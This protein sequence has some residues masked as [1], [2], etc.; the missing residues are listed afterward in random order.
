MSKMK[1]KN[2]HIGRK[3]LFGFEI[4]VLILLVGVLF[5]YT[6]I[7][8]KMDQL[9]FNKNDTQ[10]QGGEPVQVEINESVSGSEVLSGYTNVALFGI[11][12]N[13]SDTIIIASI[14]NGTKEIKMVSLYRD[15]YL[16]VAED[17]YG[18]GIYDKCN[19]AYLRGGPVSAV[20]MLNTNL[21]LDIQNYVTVDF[22]ALSKAVDCLGGLDVDLSYEEIEHTNNYCIGTSEQVEGAEYTPIEKPPVP[23]D[24]SKIIGNY[25]LNGIQVTSYCRI[26][27]TA[28]MDMGR[29][30][31][32]RYILNLMADK[33]KKSSLTTLNKILDEVFP[34]VATNFSKSELIKLGSG[35]LSYK[36]T[37][38]TGFPLDYAMGRE[39]TEPVTGLD[40]LIPTTLATN[41]K[42]L[43]EYLF[44]D[45]DYIPS[46]TVFIR[47]EFV[48]DKTGFGNAS[49]PE[50][51][52]YLIVDPSSNTGDE[53][54]EE[55][56]TNEEENLYDTESQGNYE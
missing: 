20:S 56:Y 12:E 18:N 34:M 52:Q 10:Q 19:S 8:K 45:K 49:V 21:D 2:R 40:C 54:M 32:Q 43:H 7:N 9:N 25:H 22:A 30:Q 33:A 42:Y 51:S 55:D 48:A 47:S 38:N 39:V 29:T 50:A 53:D 3:I 31:R 15:T 14:N 26:R 35:L 17:E 28:S 46:E 37:E 24:Q 11:N 16:R 13:N 27:K 5:V 23:A 36:L 6:Q 41:V 1:K 44:G 4:L